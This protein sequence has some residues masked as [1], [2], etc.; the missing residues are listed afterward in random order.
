[1]AKG[2]L[3]FIGLGL[4][5]EKDISIKGL[6]AAK[7]CDMVFAEFYTSI[8]AG[9]NKKKIEKMIGKKIEILDRNEVENGEIIL[10]YANEKK[11]AFLTA[12]DPLSATTHIDLRLRAEKQ[13]IKTKVIHGGSIFTAVPGLLG[14]QHYK[15][16]RTTTLMF[17]RGNYFPVSPYDVIYENK[18]R[19]LHTLVLLDID[20]ENNKLMT[21]NQGMETLLE[22]EK[23]K[24]KNI[25]SEESIVC[26]VA[27]ASSDAPLVKAGKIK[28]LI[29]EDFGPPLHTIVVPGDLHFMEIEALIAFAD[30]KKD[31]I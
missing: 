15:F 7:K 11:V 10:K 21:A 18:S 9:T 12:G 20:I 14:L 27:R 4:Y 22:L 3:I 17:P 28:R 26:V 30:L 23:I 13:D 2:E 29:K 19:G 24:K 5:D 8:L 25:F 16:G 6:E 31:E 1:M